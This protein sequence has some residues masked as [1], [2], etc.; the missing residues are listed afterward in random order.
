MF[1]LQAYFISALKILTTIVIWILILTLPVARHLLYHRI[2][3]KKE[4]SVSEIDCQFIVIAVHA[5][6]LLEIHLTH[7]GHAFKEQGI[8]IHTAFL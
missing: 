7:E 4:S 1:T 8:T 2:K 3:I 5:L 6:K